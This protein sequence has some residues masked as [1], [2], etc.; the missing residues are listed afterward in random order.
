MPMAMASRFDPEWAWAPYA[1]DSTR[2]WNLARAGHLLRR[3]AFG[4]S[5]E[6]LQKALADGPQRTIDRL[7][8]PAGI[9]EFEGRMSGLEA[10]LAHSE[11]AGAEECAQ[12]WIY[13]MLESPDPLHERM[14]LFWHN[15]FA[16]TGA[17][18]GKVSLLVRH[19]GL[20]HRHALGRFDALLRDIIHDP[21]TLVALNARACRKGRPP[22]LFTAAVYSWAGL[23]AP[24]NAARAF[25]GSFVLQDEYRYLANEHDDSAR[26]TGDETID[27]ILADRA[28]AVHLVRRLYR[29]L[30]S[31][32]GEIPET[33]IAPLAKVLAQDYDIGRLVATMLRS[34]LF[35]SPA[36]YRSRVKSPLDYALGIV[37][38]L[39]V[40]AAPAQLQREIGSLGQRLLE[41][42][43]RYGWPGGRHWLN[44][45]TVIRRAGLA[46]S[47]IR[48][49]KQP[50]GELWDLLVQS[51]VPAEVRQGLANL[52]GRELA[53]AIT[54]LPEFQLA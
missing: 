52:K 20:L 53:Q 14:A 47:L 48:D 40:P 54:N 35:F 13:R 41:P 30:I 46:A 28:T 44:Q 26:G 11:S 5:R 38:A 49:P 1:P 23:P 36:A 9:A 33:L 19:V 45:F 32:S 42:P 21:A 29:W 8:A 34:N 6:R 22:E 7:L 37:A 51:D 2:P 43:T 15:H 4:P 27:A 25:T 10:P 24:E 39:E 31:E 16:I 3:A 12:L 17:R 18:V 50:S